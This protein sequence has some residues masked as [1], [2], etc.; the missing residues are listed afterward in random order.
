MLPVVEEKVY[1]LWGKVMKI[2]FGNPKLSMKMFDKVKVL[3]SYVKRLNV[4]DGA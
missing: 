2:I 3:S 4:R 1:L